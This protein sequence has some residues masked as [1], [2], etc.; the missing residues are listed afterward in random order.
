MDEMTDEQRSA[1]NSVFSQIQELDYENKRLTLERTKLN[2]KIDE[3][4]MKL[5]N[6]LVKIERQ[7]TL[8]TEYLDAFR[9]V[10]C[11]ELDARLLA[12][13]KKKSKVKK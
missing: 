10:L 1:M 7:D 12:P 4:E 5:R 6:A 11:A 8:D 9:L 2:Q 3:L 13:D